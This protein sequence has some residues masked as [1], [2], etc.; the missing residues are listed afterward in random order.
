MC[1][2]DTSLQ[3]VAYWA[4]VSL[5]HSP[6]KTDFHQRQIQQAWS[7]DVSVCLTMRVCQYAFYALYANTGRKCCAQQERLVKCVKINLKKKNQAMCP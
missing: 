6:G 5:T 7:D 2:S 3:I 1:F 4:V